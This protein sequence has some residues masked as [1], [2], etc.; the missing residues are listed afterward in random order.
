MLEYLF[1]A[2]APLS[3][4][5]T[6]NSLVSSGIILI[7]ATAALGY[8]RTIGYWLFEFFT[9]RFVTQV[10]I[11]EDDDT[12]RWLA[13]FIAE[14][15]QHVLITQQHRVSVRHER[16]AG[17]YNWDTN[18]EDLLA[19]E[20]PE[21]LFTPGEGLTVLWFQRRLFFISRVS[22]TNI[23]GLIGGGNPQSDKL[24]IYTPGNAK[25]AIQDLVRTAMDYSVQKDKEKTIV[26]VLDQHMGGGWV[27]ALAKPK[28]P[29]DSVILRDQ[30]S[31]EI[32][33]DAAEFLA[34][35]EWYRQ[36]GVPYRRSYLLFGKPGCGKTSF[37][38][39]LAG[40]L[41]LNVC[42]L[43]LNKPYL[44]DDAVASQLRSAP[45]NSI[46]LI[47]DIDV[48]FPTRE[49]SQN[50]MK[51]PSNNY[52]ANSAPNVTFS[53]ILNAIDGIASQEGRIIVMTTNCKDEL[54]AA[55]L[56]PGRVDRAAE[57]KLASAAQAKQ[58]FLRFYPEEPDLAGDFSKY[59]EPDL[60]S[61]AALQGLFMMFKRDPLGAVKAAPKL[62]AD[63]RE[64]LRKEEEAKRKK[65][66]EEEKAKRT[67]K[68]K[69]LDESA[70]DL[71]ADE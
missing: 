11:R 30:V 33:Q 9:H 10:E 20:K 41:T 5:A 58:L 57:F 37:V 50:A 35:A 32:R 25:D 54:D 26:F 49:A 69:Q 14:N 47:E 40:E 8:L 71:P 27:R 6:S 46:I 21:V 7:I 52:A 59:I 60:I 45:P 70:D 39:A 4:I 61:M 15:P 1:A 28:R 38:T 13:T 62:V 53:G 64:N 24:V 67:A 34:S 56:R 51:R 63:T 22:Q 29:M 23:H 18:K 16:K 44:N 2:S 42:V 3:N 55:I 19:V 68:K 65:K 43:T 17:R 36:L 12:F 48:A 66:E 31:D